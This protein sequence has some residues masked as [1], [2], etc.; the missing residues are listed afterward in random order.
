MG[1]DPGVGIVVTL[2]ATLCGCGSPPAAPAP[3]LAPIASRCPAGF[4]EGPEGTCFS[5]PA[6]ATAA[7][8]TLLYVHSAS[9]ETTVLQELERVKAALGDSTGVL[10]ARGTEVDCG[11]SGD[12]K[13]TLCWPD[14]LA[15]ATRIWERWDK[16]QWQAEAL[17]PEGK[18]PR[19]VLG[20]QQ[21]AAFAARAFK[22]GAIQAHAVAVVAPTELEAGPYPD[23]LIGIGAPASSDALFVDLQSS[24]ARCA[25]EDTAALTPSDL[26]RA[27]TAFALVAMPASA[28]PAAAA[29]GPCSLHAAAHGAAHPSKGARH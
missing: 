3:K 18:H 15:R 16:V 22:R 19:L 24:S 11:L 6:A 17:L 4:E 20:F 9:D 21:G 14:D 13:A 8:A 5:L 28:R 12:V 29:A 2:L 10:F 27:R 25:R 26:E 7:T 23:W 1:R